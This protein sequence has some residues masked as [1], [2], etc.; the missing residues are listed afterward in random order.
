MGRLVSLSWWV[1]VPARRLALPAE[2]PRLDLDGAIG[3]G[4]H[5]EI[6]YD[7]FPRARL[8]LP[9]PANVRYLQTYPLSWDS[10]D[11]VTWYPHDP[12]P[13]IVTRTPQLP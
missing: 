12:R 4:W 5:L 10:F 8:L 2:M 6:R 9:D 13:L 1:Y 3:R 11:G 7:T